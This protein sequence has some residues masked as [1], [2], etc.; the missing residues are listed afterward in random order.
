MQKIVRHGAYPYI[1]SLFV[2]STQAVHTQRGC[3]WFKTQKQ[4]G[5]PHCCKTE[6][7]FMTFHIYLLLTIAI[8]L[9]MI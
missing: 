9:K 2:I 5:N 3:L 1:G 7:V 4:T 6:S 8:Y